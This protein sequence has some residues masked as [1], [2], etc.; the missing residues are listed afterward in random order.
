MEEE[1]VIQ[2][3]FANSAG[4]YL[5]IYQPTVE[6]GSRGFSGLDFA[7]VRQGTIH[8]QRRR[9]RDHGR[10][11]LRAPGAGKNTGFFF[12]E[13]NGRGEIRFDGFG[14]SHGAKRWPVGEGRSRDSER[15]SD[16]LLSGTNLPD[17]NTGNVTTFANYIARFA[18]AR[19]DGRYAVADK[20]VRSLVGSDTYGHMGSTYQAT[21]QASALD[22]LKVQTGRRE[23]QRPRSG[24]VGQQARIRDSSR[25][26]ERHDPAFLEWCLADR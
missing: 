6:M 20:D 9:S 15:R 12:L 14:A 10:L 4:A 2:P 8:G 11:G 19:V 23:S 22:W 7:A 3:V 24:P 5:G 17:H 21:P 26:A 1:S 25:N 16:G 18:Y 13:A